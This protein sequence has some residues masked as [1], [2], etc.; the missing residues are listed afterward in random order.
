MLERTTQTIIFSVSETFLGRG[1]SIG[2]HCCHLTAM[3][4]AEPKAKIMWVRDNKTNSHTT[5]TYDTNASLS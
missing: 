5:N 1:G 4:Y 3:D 2:L